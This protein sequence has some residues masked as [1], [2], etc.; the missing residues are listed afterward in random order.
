MN[1]AA[2]LE[3]ADALDSGEYIQTTGQLGKNGR[4]CVAGV[5]T[6]VFK[7]RLGIKKRDTHMGVEY[8]DAD[9]DLYDWAGAPSTV[10]EHLDPEGWF[11]GATLAKCMSLNDFE[12]EPFSYIADFIRDEVEKEA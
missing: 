4:Y 11:V 1:K 5:A 10:K 3:L 8:A 6:E 2:Y 12:N 9:S 7:D